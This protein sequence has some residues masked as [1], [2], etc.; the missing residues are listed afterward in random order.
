M[1]EEFT[2]PPRGE[3]VSAET[4]D[5]LAAV[6]RAGKDVHDMDVDRETIIA[7]ARCSASLSP[8]G[9]FRRVEGHIRVIRF[10]RPPV[11]VI[12]LSNAGRWC[13]RTQAP[14]LTAETR[15]QSSRVESSSPWAWRRRRPRFPD[16]QWKVAPPASSVSSS[17]I[18]LAIDID[19]S[20]AISGKSLLRY[21]M[22]P[23]GNACSSR[24][25]LMRVL[26]RASP[27]LCGARCTWR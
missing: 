11:P 14:G 21:A 2:C 22:A 4:D 15:V 23:L 10:D 6:V 13:R 17:R 27:S 8:S 18:R 7:G 12:W 26:L 24:S 9:C 20:C 1:S 3:V 16:G 19:T 5:E 25:P